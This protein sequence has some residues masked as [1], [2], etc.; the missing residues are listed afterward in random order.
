MVECPRAVSAD[1]FSSLVFLSLI[2]IRGFKYHTGHGS[3]L[4]IL[5]NS[6]IHISSQHLYLDP[7]MCITSGLLD[8]TT[9]MSTCMSY[10]IGSTPNSWC[11]RPKSAPPTIFLI[12]EMVTAWFQSLKP[13]TWGYLTPHIN[14]SCQLYLQHTRRYPTKTEF[15]Y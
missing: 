14:K 10:L 6:H 7:H 9:W 1:L 4:Y 15:I 2:Q 13:K 12:S 11:L 5:D 8:I 3:C